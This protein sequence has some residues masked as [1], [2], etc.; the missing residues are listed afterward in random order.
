MLKSAYGH[1][2]HP[3]RQRGKIGKAWKIVEGAGR[4]ERDDVQ[5]DFR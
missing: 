4:R 5:L 3:K 2:Q 1:S